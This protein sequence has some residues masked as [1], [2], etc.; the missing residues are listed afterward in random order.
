MLDRINYLIN[1]LKKQYDRKT[2]YRLREDFDELKDIFTAM[3]KK[4]LKAFKS[5]NRLIEEVEEWSVSDGESKLTKIINRLLEDYKD[6][7]T[8]C[9]QYK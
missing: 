6:F 1:G 2:I 4:V 3:V 7:R 9:L 5:Y 8:V